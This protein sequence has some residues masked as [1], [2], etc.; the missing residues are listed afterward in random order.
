MK[1][2]IFTI[3]GNQEDRTGN[4]IPY[5][6]STHAGQWKPKVIRYNKWK[7][8]V[9]DAFLA[10][11]VDEDTYH[12][13]DFKNLI[14]YFLG[15]PIKKSNIKMQMH[16]SIYYKDHKHCD[17]DNLFKGIADALFEDDKYLEG[18]FKFDYA[19]AGRVDVMIHFMDYEVGK[20]RNI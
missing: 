3:P 18:S 10:K 9:K 12:N 13:L 2:I 5:T 8:Y 17:S 7:E 1:S 15:K 16:L 20:S 11:C 6:R 14:A 19:L 4:P